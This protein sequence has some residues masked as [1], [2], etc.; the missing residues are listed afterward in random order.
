VRELG[1][2][3]TKNTHFHCLSSLSWGLTRKDRIGSSRGFG[4]EETRMAKN[5]AKVTI[6]RQVLVNNF[7]MQNRT[8]RQ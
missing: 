1:T 6:L 3:S 4:A 7:L 2:Q 5:M 8:F